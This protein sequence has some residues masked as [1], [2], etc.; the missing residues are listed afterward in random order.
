MLTPV[1]TITGNL[2]VSATIYILIHIDLITSLLRHLF[3][4]TF[5]ADLAEI[6]IDNLMI[7][8]FKRSVPFLPL[9]CVGPSW[10]VSHHLKMDSECL[11]RG[12]S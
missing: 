10:A 5:T 8:H 3:S 1:A 6:L 2:A 9:K 12:L 4:R 7:I 11:Y